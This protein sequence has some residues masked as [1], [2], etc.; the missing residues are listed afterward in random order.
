MNIHSESETPSAGQI[1]VP[2]LESTARSSGNAHAYEKFDRATR[3]A[4]A[5]VTG[6]VSPHSIIAT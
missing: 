3:A 1:E 5:R 2:V 6:G 4:L